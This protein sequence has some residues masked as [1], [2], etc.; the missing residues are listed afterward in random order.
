MKSKF[1]KKVTRT[2]EEF[3][4]LKRKDRVLVAVSGGPDSMALLNVLFELK[5]EYEL[6]LFVAHLNHGL[7]GDESDRD[8]QFVKEYVEKMGLP[9]YIKKVSSEVLKCK[10]VSLEERARQVRYEYFDELAEELNCQ[11]IALGHTADDQ[12]ETILMRF[13]RGSGI[14]GLSGIPPVRKKGRIIRPLI[15]VFRDEVIRYLE[16]RKIPYMIDSTNKAQDFLRNRIRQKL[17]PLIEKEFNQGIKKTLLRLGDLFRVEDE[18]IEEIVKSLKGVA[19]ISK[20][21]ATI[22][23]EKFKKLNKGEKLRIL[24]YVLRR[25]L[26]DLRQIELI[27]LEEILEIVRS[28]KPNQ[29]VYLPR[30]L[31]VVKEYNQLK[32]LYNKNVLKRDEF[33]VPLKINGK[34]LIGTSG[35]IIESKLIMKKSLKTLKTDSKTA[36]LDYE[37]LDSSLYFRNYKH[38]DRFIPLGSLGSKKLKDFF[39][40]EKVPLTMRYRIPILVSGNQIVWVAGYRIDD[41]FKVTDKTRQVL[42]LRIKRMGG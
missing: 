6:T 20:G 13:L 32:I 4:M 41:R 40:D 37:K 18:L 28:S 2:I 25:L 5:D 26:G 15:N 12:A 16:E 22:D 23:L 42:K 10:G 36:L 30:G 14:K 7:R 17:I 19:K 27:H 34:T 33:N 9:V 21:T 35:F 11:R 24:R 38:G 39:I 8:E 1:T 3:N 29:F 31:L